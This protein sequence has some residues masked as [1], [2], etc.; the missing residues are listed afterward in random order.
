MK[1]AFYK[2]NA[3]KKEKLDVMIDKVTG[4][5]GYSH[6]EL[7]FSDGV[8]FSSSPREGIVRYKKIDVSDALSWTVIDVP[9]C[10]IYDENRSRRIADKL[11]GCKYD[12]KGIV[13]DQLIP[14]SIDNG[15]KWWCSEVVAYVLGVYPYKINPNQLY[16]K[17]RHKY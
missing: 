14:L 5:Y 10:H 2:S 3:P 13:L 9:I 8:C 16:L 17:F 11:I 1:L 7:V 15:D 6:V 12:Y 4:G